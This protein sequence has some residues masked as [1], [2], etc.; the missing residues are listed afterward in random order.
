MRELPL[1]GIFVA[2][3]ELPFQRVGVSAVNLCVEVVVHG[4]SSTIAVSS[5]VNPYNSHSSETGTVEGEWLGTL[6]CIDRDSA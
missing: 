2:L 6:H 3:Y 5:W 1:Q 4:G